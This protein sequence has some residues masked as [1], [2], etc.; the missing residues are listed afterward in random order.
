MGQKSVRKILG[1]P[2]R[3]NGGVVAFWNYP[4]G[5]DVTFMDGKVSGWSEPLR[6]DE[7]SGNAS[8]SDID[9]DKLVLGILL[10]AI[11]F[12]FT[13]I[14]W[15]LFSSRSTGGAKFGWFLITIVFSWLGFA[16]FLILTQTAKARKQ[17]ESKTY[18]GQ[19]E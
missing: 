9:P 12:Y 14:L 3:I 1:E 6:W 15:V 2:E 13:P 10:V 11:L 8:S 17:L 5:G 16:A 4:N 19:S 18:G 7:G